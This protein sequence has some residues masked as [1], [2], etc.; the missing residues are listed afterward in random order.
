MQHKTGFISGFVIGMAGFL[1]LF[2]FLFLDRIPPSDE[3]AP[4]IVVLISILNG[5]LF[6][7]VG[8]SIQ[9]RLNN[10]STPAESK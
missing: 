3:V 2:K 10:S 8:R 7:F 9:R 6:A 5:M 4:G 1:V